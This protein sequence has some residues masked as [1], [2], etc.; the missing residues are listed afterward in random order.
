M[1][2]NLTKTPMAAIV[3]VIL[4]LGLAI[5]APQISTSLLSAYD[6]HF[7]VLT[8]TGSIVKVEASAITLKI[9][10]T[11]HRGEECRLVSVYGYTLSADGIKH[12]A[13][14]ERVDTPAMGR[15]RD[16]GTYDI[17]LW[18]VYPVVSNAVSLEVWTHHTCVNRPV[19]SKISDVK[20]K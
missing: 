4:G 13:I 7:P 9:S 5:M 1:I 10:G 12:D 3:G 20:L 19:L 17:G 8:M 14:A 11:K 6:N 16:K 18:R 2:H 15:I